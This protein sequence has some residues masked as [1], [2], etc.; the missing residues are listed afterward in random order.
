[1]TLHAE[2]A[3]IVATPHVEDLVGKKL[4]NGDPLV[5]LVSTDN[6]IVDVEVPEQDVELIKTG[7]AASLKLESF[8]ATTF[9]GTVSGISPLGQA[10]GD[11]HFFFARILLPN[12]DGRLRPGMQGD[13]KIRVG[14]RPLGYVLFRDPALWIWSTLWSW[15]SW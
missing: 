10:I 6:V 15:F 9:R 13:G 2:I 8:P 14:M 7:A 5:E 4:S 1:M 11:R 12:A 3:G